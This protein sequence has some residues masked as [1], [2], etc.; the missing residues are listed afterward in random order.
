MR[1]PQLSEFRRLIQAGAA[2]QD[3]HD[4]DAASGFA[5]TDG[6]ADD[7]FVAREVD[8]VAIHQRSLTPLLEETVCEADRVLDFG[9]GTGGTSVALALS[10]LGAREVVGLDASAPAIRA[11]RVRAAGHDLEPPALRFLTHG[12][13]EDLPFPDGHFDL[14][15]TVSVLEFI[16]NAEHRV[17][18]VA[19]LRRVVRAGGFLYIATPWPRLYEYHSGRLLGDLFRRDGMPW[20]SPPWEV[21]TWADGWSRIPLGEQLV[22]RVT[23]RLPW[24]PEPLVKRGLAPALPYLSRWNKI[25]LRRPDA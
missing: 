22:G 9:C 1:E 15:V 7:A 3:I 10:A 16:T 21:A 20:S 17:R 23:E 14:A 6:E 8:R 11:A 24:L 13:G 2:S 25:L 18:T 4:A 12:A 19:E 5:V